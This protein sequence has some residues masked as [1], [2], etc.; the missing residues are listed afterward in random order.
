LSKP[1][2]RELLEVLSRQPYDVVGLTLMRECPSSAIANLIKA[3]RNVSSNPHISILIGGN[4]I[5]QNP[6]IVAEVGADGTGA[7]ARAALEVA[8]RLV[9]RAPVRAH[10]VR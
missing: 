8:Q 4:M 9:D 10:M 5:N 1:Q 3:M 7:D 2:R 6:G